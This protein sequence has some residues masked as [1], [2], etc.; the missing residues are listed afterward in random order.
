[1]GSPVESNKRKYPR[2]L[3][4]T[5]VDVETPMGAFNAMS[6]NITPEGMFIRTDRQVALDT[7]VRVCFRF[8]DDGHPVGKRATVVR[9]LANG[10]G[11]AFETPLDFL[12]AEEPAAVK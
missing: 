6:V 8:N 11:V 7:P 1:M 2:G 4:V 12:L 10:I 3:F 9:S 5:A